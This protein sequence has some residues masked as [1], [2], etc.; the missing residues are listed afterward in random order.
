MMDE[1]LVEDSLP[2]LTSLA[3][4]RQYGNVLCDMTTGTHFHHGVWDVTL[5]PR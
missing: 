1:V 5:L 2:R 4:G 3:I